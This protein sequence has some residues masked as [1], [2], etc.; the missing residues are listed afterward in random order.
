M[1]WVYNRSTCFAS[2]ACWM[3]TKLVLWYPYEFFGSFP[4]LT[5]STLLPSS[6]QATFHIFFFL[7]FFFCFLFFQ[8]FLYPSYDFHSFSSSS[9]PFY[10]RTFLLTFLTESCSRRINIFTGPSLLYKSD[11]WKT[12]RKEKER[13]IE[14]NNVKF[15]ETSSTCSRI[16]NEMVPT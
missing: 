10:F 12:P 3:A 1:I 8:T 13:K 15:S 7:S 11:S 5:F 4:Q 14:E 6:S 16:A 2:M 9:L